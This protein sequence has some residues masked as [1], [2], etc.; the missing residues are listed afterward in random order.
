[1]KRAKNRREE[2]KKK[3]RGNGPWAVANRR[4]QAAELAR[5]AADLRAKTAN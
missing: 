2:R 1:M 3:K 4:R 5:N